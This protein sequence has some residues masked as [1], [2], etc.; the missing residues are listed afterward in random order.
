MTAE[1]AHDGVCMTGLPV[2]WLCCCRVPGLFAFLRR[3]YP[4]ICSPVE[5]RKGLGE[6]GRPQ[7]VDNLYIGK[8]LFPCCR[9]ARKLSCSK[10]RTT[11]ARSRGLCCC[12]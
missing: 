9:T 1:A 7:H 12:G 10:V 11:I 6:D 3:R 5:K 4:Q 8:Q 2:A